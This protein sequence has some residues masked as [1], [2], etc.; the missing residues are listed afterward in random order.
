MNGSISD[1]FQSKASLSNY[2]N[3]ELTYDQIY[4]NRGVAINGPISAFF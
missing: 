4:K 3:A 1:F 2:Q